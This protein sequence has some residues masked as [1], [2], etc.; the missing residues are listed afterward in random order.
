[1]TAAPPTVGEDALRGLIRLS[2]QAE[3]TLVEFSL[4]LSQYRV[5]DRLAGGQAAGKSL[6]EWLAV[7]PPTVTALVD[8]LV[9]RGLVR[10][11]TDEHDRRRVTHELTDLGQATYAAVSEAIAARLGHVATHAPSD[12]AARRMVAALASWNAAL[13]STASRK[14]AISASAR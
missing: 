11:S 6:A 3:M 8:G 2:R 5:L 14:S 10:R 12:A 7:R 1:M 13:A 4:S 9:A